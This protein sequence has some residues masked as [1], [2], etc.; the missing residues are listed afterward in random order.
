MSNGTRLA[1][2]IPIIQTGS[3]KLWRK[4]LNPFLPSPQAYT[5]GP[6]CVY[7]TLGRNGLLCFFIWEV[8][9]IHQLLFKKGPNPHLFLNVGELRAMEMKEA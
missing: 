7:A 1:H 2:I 9:K 6:C 5:F 8:G 3:L 4:R